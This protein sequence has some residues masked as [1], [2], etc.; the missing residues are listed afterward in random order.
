MDLNQLVEDG[1]E[2]IFPFSTPF[3][4][5]STDSFVC[6]ICNYFSW[7]SFDNQHLIDRIRMI[8]LGKYNC[9]K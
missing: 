4:S 9:Q 3:L 2:F 8:V 5:S 6:P 7:H 1:R